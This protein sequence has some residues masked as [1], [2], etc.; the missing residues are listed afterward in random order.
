MTSGAAQGKE[1]Q[2]TWICC[3]GSRLA[4]GRESLSCWGPEAR[5]PERER[6]HRKEEEELVEGGPSGDRASEQGEAAVTWPTGSG[7]FQRARELT[8]GSFRTPEKSCCRALLERPPP[9]RITACSP[10]S[11][12]GP[13]CHQ[14]TQ[15]P[16]WG[17]QPRATSPPAP[18]APRVLKQ[19]GRGHAERQMVRAEL[20]AKT[21]TRKSLVS[22]EMKTKSSAQQFTCS[23]TSHRPLGQALHTHGLSPTSYKRERG[24]HA[25]P[26][27]LSSRPTRELSVR[28]SS[29]DPEG[30]RRGRG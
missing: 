10:Q 7:R 8:R 17:L 14:P 15:P 24:L 23:G 13:C 20:Q 12:Q 1:Q 2:N 26:P 4:G 18:T 30:G 28:D 9:R 5:V 19:N 16:F 6:T 21:A 11:L 3:S 29:G 22:G 27:R 25:R